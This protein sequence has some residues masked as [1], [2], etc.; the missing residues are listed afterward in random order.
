[1]SAYSE[2]V[3]KLVKELSRLP[4]I[5]PRSAERIVF[6][7]LKSDKVY[8][9]LLSDLLLKVK[10]EVFFCQVCHNLSEDKLCHICRNE[11]R[12]HRTICVVEE[13]KDVISLEKSGG[14][15]GVYHVLLGVLSPLS[16]IGPKELKIRE[17]EERVKEG[18]VQEIVLATN[19]NTDGEA[20]ALYLLKVLKP[21]GVKLTRI[22]RGIPLGSNLEYVDHDTLACAIEGRQEML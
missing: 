22:A 13:P 17:L 16:G 9:K 4:G 8:V 5:G 15:K 18:G 1:M 3:Q 21:Y 6:Y 10:E 14:F 20:T 7:L 2:L 12:D 11:T 19:F